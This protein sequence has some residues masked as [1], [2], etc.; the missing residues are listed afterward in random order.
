MLIDR[1][2]C[3]GTTH[4]FIFFYFTYFWHISLGKYMGILTDRFSYTSG[5]TDVYIFVYPPTN[6]FS[7]IFLFLTYFAWK[8]YRNTDRQV[9]WHVRVDWC[10]IFRLENIWEYWQ[11]AA[12]FLTCPG[13]LM[14][15][16]RQVFCRLHMHIHI[17]YTNIQVITHTCEEDHKYLSCK[18]SNK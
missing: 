4:Q 11:T 3:R 13:R 7:F 5:S 2:P 16:D 1:T 17:S 15:T 8:I 6:L 12:G 18:G 14:N 9:F 10:D